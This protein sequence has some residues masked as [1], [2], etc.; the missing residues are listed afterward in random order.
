[1]SDGTDGATRS[2]STRLTVTENGPILADGDITLIDGERRF[3]AHETQTAFC[4]CG[5]SSNKPVCDGSHA[6]VGFGASAALG[7]GRVKPADAATPGALT[8]RLRAQ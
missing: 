2:P 7:E 3:L 1:M 4:R 8:V 6:K 5:A